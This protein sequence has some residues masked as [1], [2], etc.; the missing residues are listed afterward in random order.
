MKT[1]NP[2]LV[3][4]TESNKLVYLREKNCNA[5]VA[6][7][8]LHITVNDT[9]NSFPWHS[10]LSFDLLPIHIANI[11]NNNLSW[12]LENIYDIDSSFE[13]ATASFSNTE[14]DAMSSILCSL[15][16]YWFSFLVWCGSTIF[17]VPLPRCSIHWNYSGQTLVKKISNVIDLFC[18]IVSSS[19]NSY[20]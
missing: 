4:E 6:I 9:L 14:I 5:T 15:S 2:I 7:P 11:S 16:I 17:F 20:Q 13:N 18:S 10:P 19:K 12:R 1:N 3:N 8:T